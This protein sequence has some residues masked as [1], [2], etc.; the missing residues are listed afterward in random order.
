MI[1]RKESLERGCGLAVR[2]EDGWVLKVSL[3]IAKKHKGDD[4]VG[5]RGTWQKYCW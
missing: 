2:C 3:K 5:S 1:R 4:K